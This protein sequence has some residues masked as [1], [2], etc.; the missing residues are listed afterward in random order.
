MSLLNLPEATAHVFMGPDLRHNIWKNK[1]E[2]TSDVGVGCRTLWSLTT[3]P[4][5]SL[6]PAPCPAMISKRIVRFIVVHAVIWP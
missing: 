6:S 4:L 1:V 2:S 5:S 3:R